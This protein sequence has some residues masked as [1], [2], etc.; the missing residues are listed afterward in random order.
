[1]CSNIYNLSRHHDKM[2]MRPVAFS[3]MRPAKTQIR[4]VWSE[5]SLC[6]QWVAKDPSFLLAD[7]EDSDQT[8]WM[9]RLIWVLAGRTVTLLVLSWGGSFLRYI[10]T[11]FPLTRILVID[12]ARLST[13]LYS[14]AEHRRTTYHSL[15]IPAFVINASSFLLTGTPSTW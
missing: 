15:C 5:S 14:S 8:G 13:I 2:T 6:T 7:S 11:C 10:L 3:T 12:G 4:P 9:P 1:M